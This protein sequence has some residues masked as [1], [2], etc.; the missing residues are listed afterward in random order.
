MLERMRK[1]AVEHGHV[2]ARL[3]DRVIVLVGVAYRGDFCG[4]VREDVRTMA[5]LRKTLGY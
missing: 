2:A 5:E 1:I 3:P 4:Y